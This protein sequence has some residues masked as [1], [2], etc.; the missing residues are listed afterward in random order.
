MYELGKPEKQDNTVF[1][2]ELIKQLL[3]LR[4]TES[5]NKNYAVGDLVV[6][7][8]GWRTHTISNGEDG[9]IQKTALKIDP[10]ISLPSS[11]ALGILGMTG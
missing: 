7:D 9:F 1:Q 2:T 5:K 3:S 10:S 8:F 6:G 11:T 4:V